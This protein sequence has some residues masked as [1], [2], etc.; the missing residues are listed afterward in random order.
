MGAIAFVMAE[1]IRVPYTT[2]RHGGRGAGSAL[3]RHRVR[4]G[5]SA[6]APQ[7]HRADARARTC[8]S[9]VPPS[10]KAGIYLIPI[11]ALIYFL[12][13]ED[14]PPG[15]AGV[16]TFPFVIGASFLSRD[17]GDWLLPRNLIAACSS[18]G[19]RLGD[20]RRHHRLRRHH[21]RRHRT[22]RHRRQDFDP[23]PRP[24]RRQPDRHAGAGGAWRASSWAWGSIRFPSTSRSRR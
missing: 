16:L 9:S 20:D 21:D 12:L 4:L 18:A 1:W 3:F 15:M 23:D 13:I 5:A 7:R 19:A 8:R 2:D 11:A 6:G 24:L 10:A 17:R 14:Y 22:Q